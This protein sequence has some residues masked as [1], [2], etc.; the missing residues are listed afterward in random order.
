MRAWNLLRSITGS[1][2]NGNAKLRG[3]RRARRRL[4]VEALEARQMLAILFVDDNF[5]N[6][7]IGQDPDGAGPATNFGTD[8]FATIQGAINAASASGDTV[9]VY[10]GNYPENLV[11][12]SKTLTLQGAQSGVDA[13][14]RIVGSPNP[15]T[16]SIVAPV[17]GRALELQGN[18]GGVIVDG[19]AFIG[20]LNGASGV[21]ESTT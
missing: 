14:G 4:H 21:I 2:G 1:F 5:A 17:A 18:P 6:P 7:T 13:R 20:S 3:W 15:A 8:S 9:S 16:E 10:A 11:I 19:F 12:P